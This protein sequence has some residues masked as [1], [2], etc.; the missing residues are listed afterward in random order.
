[1]EHEEAGFSDEVKYPLGTEVRDT[2][3]P[4]P[5]SAADFYYFFNRYVELTARYARLFGWL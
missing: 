2:P 5:S 3:D 1:M 4:P